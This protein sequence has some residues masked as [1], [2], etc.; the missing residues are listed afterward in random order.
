ME[1]ALVGFL[2]FLLAIG[3]AYALIPSRDDVNK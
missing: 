1:E 3:I 2:G